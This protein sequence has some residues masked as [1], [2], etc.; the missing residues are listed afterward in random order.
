VLVRHLD[1]ESRDAVD[2]GAVY[3]CGPNVGNDSWVDA[4][5][6]RIGLQLGFNFVFGSA[7]V[8]NQT[9]YNRKSVSTS[10][11]I[12]CFACI[13]FCSQVGRACDAVYRLPLNGLLEIKALSASLDGACIAAVIPCHHRQLCVF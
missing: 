7:F 3:Y 10:S 11:M 12:C 9:I 1:H 5:W 6:F 8:P 4:F 13:Y 2:E